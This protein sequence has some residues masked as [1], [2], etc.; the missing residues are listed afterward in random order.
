MDKKYKKWHPIFDDVFL[1]SNFRHA[2]G[3]DILHEMLERRVE[4]LGLISKLGIPIEELKEQISEMEKNKLFF[5]FKEKIK[6]NINNNKFSIIAEMKRKSPSAGI[7][8]KKYNPVEIAKTYDKNNATCLSVL[9]EPKFFGG[10]FNHMLDI[11]NAGIKLPI[12]CKDFM[13]TMW[14]L[15]L[16]RSRGADAILIILSAFDYFVKEKK[17]FLNQLYEEALKLNMSVIIEVHT[18]EEAERALKFKEALIGINNRNLSTLTTDLNATYSINN[19]LR[20]FSGPLICE[21]GIKD[22][23]D[24]LDINFKTKIKTFLIGESLLKNLDKNSIFSVL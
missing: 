16:A 23:Q 9:T 8:V 1:S 10:E 13:V 21:S 20:D 5:N 18:I 14:Q 17:F 15:Y 12:L 3:V 24:V 4:D 22:K 7:L 11:K 19:A 6:N 2:K